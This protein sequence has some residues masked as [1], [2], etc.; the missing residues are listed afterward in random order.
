MEQ[1][2]LRGGLLKA[3][4]MKALTYTLPAYWASYLINDDASGLEPG[5]Q[6]TVDAWLAKMSLPMPASCSEESHFSKHNDAGQ[7][8]G[9]VLDYTFLI[10]TP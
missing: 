4:T 8:A 6:A 2:R 1:L 5:E 10:P 3:Q 9:E 7:L